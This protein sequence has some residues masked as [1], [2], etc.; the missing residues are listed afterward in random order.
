MNQKVE[1]P[2][3]SAE[4]P[5][6]WRATTSTAFQSPSPSPFLP[7]TSR[8][9]GGISAQESRRGSSALVIGCWR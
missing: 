6:S 4:S 3:F 1:N 7:I 8:C 9:G 5:H 2:P